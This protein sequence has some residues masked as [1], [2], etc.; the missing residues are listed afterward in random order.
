MSVDLPAPFSPRRAWT[1]PARRSK[2]TLSFATIRPKRFVIPRS[3]SAAS[4]RWLRAVLGRGAD[5]VRRR[6]LAALDLVLDLLE[7]IGVL[8]PGRADLADADPVVLEVGDRVGAALER[9]VL[10]RLD[11]VEDRHVDLLERARQHLRA[12]VGL[13]RVDADALDA[14]LLRGV[15]RPESALAGD[16]EDD[17]RALGDLVERDLLALRLVDEVLRVAVERLDAGVGLLR[18]RLVAGDVVVDRRDLLAA[19]RADHAAVVLRVEA[20][21]VADEVPGLLLLEDEALH[22]LGLVLERGVGLVDDREVHVG[23]L[24]GH[25]V[26]RVGHEETDA[27]DEVVLLLGQRREV[28]DVVGVG[29]RDEDAAGDAELLDGVLEAL[30][31]QEVERAVVQAADVG[32]DADLDL[33]ALRRARR[34]A[35]AAAAAAAVVVAAAAAAAG[36]DAEG[37]DGQ[38][39]G[40]RDRPDGRAVHCS[41]FVFLLAGSGIGPRR[42]GIYDRAPSYPSTRPSSAA[43][44]SGSAKL[45]SIAVRVIAS[46]SAPSSPKCSR[47]SAYSAPMLVP[48]Y[49]GSSEPSVTRTPASRSA[50]NGWCSRSGNTRRATLLDGQHSSTVPRSASSVTRNG[51]SIARTPCAMRVTGRSSAARTLCAPVHSPA[52]TLQP[53]P[54]RW[55]MS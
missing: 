20:G 22:V 41:S 12:E 47:A 28:R 30:V 6:D 40:D 35:A 45:A 46:R 53:R 3:S 34:G 43:R 38:R 17:L 33:L 16:V 29:L 15:E 2:S 36:R 25:G 31:G 10:H 32:D 51:S 49:G 24:R 39:E 48:K 18:A 5:L 14:L 1:S 54:A 13:V 4:M 21:E 19:D 26:E 50:P 8:L 27:D 44:S 23:E 37:A 7:L 52:W 42:R 55:A 9:A 11:G